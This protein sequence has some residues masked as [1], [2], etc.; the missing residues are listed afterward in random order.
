[1]TLH[2]LG[3]RFLNLVTVKNAL[4][5]SKAA[6]VLRSGKTRQRP[7]ISAATKGFGITPPQMVWGNQV[8]KYGEAFLLATQ[9]NFPESIITPPMVVPWPLSIIGQLRWWRYQRHDRYARH[10]KQVLPRYYLR[11]AV[12]PCLW[13]I[14]LNAANQQYL[15]AGLPNRFTQNYG[16]VL[17]SIKA[18]KPA[19][20]S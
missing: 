3:S 16:L 18:S 4:M 9:S 6:P 10:K 8:V 12:T 1:M 13:A 11:W 14:R 5:W 2:S 15:P 20:S 7:N 17:S 19:K